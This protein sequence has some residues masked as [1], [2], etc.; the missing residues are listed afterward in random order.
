MATT[1]KRTTV[2]HSPARRRTD[3]PPPLPQRPSFGRPPTDADIE[4]PIYQPDELP[5]PD[6]Q[7]PEGE[8]NKVV[9]V[10]E[11]QLE[12]SREMQAMGIE[13]WKQAHDERPPDEQ[14]QSVQGVGP[15]EEQQR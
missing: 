1:I 14:Q 5:P 13:A 11:E 7:A 4:Q 6:E 10:G 12:R 3:A 8:E 9:T 2:H 15:Y